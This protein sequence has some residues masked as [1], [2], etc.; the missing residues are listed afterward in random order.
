MD[1]NDICPKYLLIKQKP[2][3]VKKVNTKWIVVKMN[4]F[5]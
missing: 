1:E 3:L 2:G 5:T 4:K